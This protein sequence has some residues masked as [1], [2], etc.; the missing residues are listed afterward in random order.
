[1]S[2]NKKRQLE[3]VIG[4]TVGGGHKNTLISCHVHIQSFSLVPRV[5]G[6]SG[7]ILVMSRKQQS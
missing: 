2:G 3:F 1:M 5:P 4:N 7:L 6:S